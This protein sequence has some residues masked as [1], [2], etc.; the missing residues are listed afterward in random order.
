M[1]RS[2]AEAQ[3]QP[4]ETPLGAVAAPTPTPEPMEVGPRAVM[5]PPWATAPVT[6]RRTAPSVAFAP[7]AAALRLLAGAGQ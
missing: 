7:V 4:K 5:G 1:T 3:G 2:V 6:S